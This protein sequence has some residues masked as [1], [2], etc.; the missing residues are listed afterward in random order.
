MKYYEGQGLLNSAIN[1]LP[2]EFHIPKYNWCGPGTKVEKRLARNDPGIN[3]LDEACKEHDIFYSKEKDLSQ[4]HEADKV[5]A[6]KA[7]KRFKASD[8]SWKEKI[9]A[10]GVAGAMKA[11]V[12]LGMG[13]N[14]N[15]S[16]T[17]VKN[18]QKIQHELELPLKHIRHLISQLQNSKNIDNENVNNQNKKVNDKKG[19][20]RK[21]KKK[22]E[23]K[24][25]QDIK[26]KKTKLSDTLRKKFNKRKNKK[27]DINDDGDDDDDMK[28]DVDIADDYPMN[29]IQRKRKLEDDNHNSELKYPKYAGIK[30]KFNRI[31]EQSEENIQSMKKNRIDLNEP[32]I[33]PH[34]YSRKR[35]LNRNGGDGGDDIP[36]KVQVVS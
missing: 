24:P 2:V 26:T 28:M 6:S 16:K 3:K 14:K 19:V 36:Q 21:K 31:N 25:H 15:D 11:K 35:K 20:E 10:L 30:R 18:L 1:N 4:R 22:S 23:N 29:R 34:V 33:L 27:K 32:I 9:A 5:L 7:F 12:K 8:A 13:L 17:M